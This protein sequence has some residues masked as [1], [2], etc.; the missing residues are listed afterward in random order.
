M[1]P[2]TQVKA[3]VLTKSR[4]SDNVIRLKIKNIDPVE[5]EFTPGQFISLKID[6][7]TYRS[8]SIYRYDTD[9]HAFEI[10]VSV[11]HEGPGPKFLKGISVGSDIEYVGPRGKFVLNTESEEVYLFA[12]GTG[13]SP[14]IAYLSHVEKSPSKPR[15]TLFWGLREKKNIFL[16]N[17]FHSFTMS[18]P[19]F[20][21]EIYLSQEKGVFQYKGGK[22]TEAAKDLTFGED[23]VFYLCGNPDMVNDMISIL[24]AKGVT[25]DRIMFEKYTRAGDL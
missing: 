14:F 2:P 7:T 25:E 19:N 23:A 1:M 8:Y 20:K 4:L 13:I 15:I 22:I 9:I 6:E 16:E 12:T 10:A 24:K 5:V 11:Y 3:K 17:M 21:H 18:L